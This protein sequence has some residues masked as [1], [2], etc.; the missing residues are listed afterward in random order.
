MYSRKLSAKLG[1]L[2][3]LAKL[4]ARRIRETS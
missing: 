3:D 4:A 1:G 2:V